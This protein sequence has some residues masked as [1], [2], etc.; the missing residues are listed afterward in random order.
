VIFADVESDA[1]GR[2]PSLSLVLLLLSVGV[3]VVLRR[4]GRQESPVRVSRRATFSL[5]L[6]ALGYLALMLVVPLAVVFG[7]AFEH[8]SALLASVTTPAA[9][10][11]F[12]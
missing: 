2:R 6:V 3:L 7:R 4:L 10:S 12:G 9:I 8:V 1:P 5:R 11:A